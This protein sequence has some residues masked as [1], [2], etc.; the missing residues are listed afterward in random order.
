LK[1]IGLDI[2]IMNLDICAAN[3][4]PKY[5][6]TGANDQSEVLRDEELGKEGNG[7][8][9]RDIILGTGPEPDR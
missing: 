5:L 4:R 7:I 6:S 8:G 2:Y 1:A 9:L 3:L